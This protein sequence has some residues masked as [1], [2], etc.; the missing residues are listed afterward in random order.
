MLK[1]ASLATVVAASTLLLVPAVPGAGEA[2]AQMTMNLAS[3]GRGS[4]VSAIIEGFNHGV[5]IP[6]DAVSARARGRRV[7]KPFTVRKRIDAS[8]PLLYQA[9]ANSET[10]P[11]V[12]I[13]VPTTR[14]AGGPTMTITLTEA[15]IMSIMSESFGDDLPMEEVSFNYAKIKWTSS[16]GGTEYEDD[17]RANN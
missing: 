15:R 7:H 16:E 10:I 6:Q 13:R 2:Q 9:L 3:A 11:A 14:A 12:T 5:M 4:G 1:H 17:W 8:T